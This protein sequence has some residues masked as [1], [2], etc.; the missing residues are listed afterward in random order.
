M[1]LFGAITVAL[2]A[3][4]SLHAHAAASSPSLGTAGNF[5]VLGAATVT[6]TGPTM[7][8]GDLGVSP[9][10]SCT[11]FPSPCT[12]GPGSVSG[13]VHVAD[14]G[15][16]QAQTDA[17]SAYLVAA[18]QN[19]TV[20]FSP[21]TDIGG[22][23]LTPGV[24]CF[25]S[26]AGITGTLI[27]DAQGNPNAGFIFKIGSTLITASASKVILIN[28]AQP[29]SVFWQVGSSATLG[30]TTEFRRKHRGAGFYY[31]YN[32]CNIELRSV[33]P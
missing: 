1:L 23:I 5:A 19:C 30:T 10:P 14:A 9:G 27:L 15:A 7:L 12:G 22:M 13:V 25:P 33:C 4:P 32:C 26:S 28:G 20:T 11:G 29:S 21:I 6:N 2:A 3:L 16:T 17:T 24:Y 31:C 8:K 18:T